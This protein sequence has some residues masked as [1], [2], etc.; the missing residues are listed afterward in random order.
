[1]FGVTL[2]KVL[3]PELRQ[4]VEKGVTQ[5]YNHL[6]QQHH[7]HQQVYGSHLK[8]YPPNSKYSF[9]YKNINHN[10]TIKGGIN[11]PAKAQYD[12]KV[13]A[14]IDLAR[15]YL[16]THMAKFNGFADA[17][18]SAL[19][20]LINNIDDTSCS[21]P[22]FVR[23]Q[24]AAQMVKER[25]NQWAHGEDDLKKWDKRS[26]QDAFNEMR[27]LLS[28]VYGSA[29]IPGQVDKDLDKWLVIGKQTLTNSSI[30]CTD[31]CILHKAHTISL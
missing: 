27:N 3:V 13:S 9:E 1:M 10:H 26:L 6:K 25:R 21:D 30:Y 17:D 18:P 22:R 4:F 28:A 15:L 14:P 29:P 5:L 8:K 16:Q 23:V 12:Y 31:S 7:I 19:L 24:A 20:G 11:N 2:Q